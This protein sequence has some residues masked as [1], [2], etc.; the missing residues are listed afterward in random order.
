MKQCIVISASSA[1]V[2]QIQDALQLCPEPCEIIEAV[3]LDDAKDALQAT[4]TLVIVDEAFEKHS[5]AAFLQKA[6]QRC[7]GSWFISV[8]DMPYPEIA[9]LSMPLQDYALSFFTQHVRNESAES[10]TPQEQLAKV[11]PILLQHFWTGLLN[12]WIVPDET[13]IMMAAKGMYLDGLQSIHV[14]PIL[15][16]T[17]HKSRTEADKEMAAEHHLYFTNLIEREI[18]IKRHYGCALDRFSQKWAILLYIEKF[19]C[20]KE[21]LH[22]RFT[23]A[24]AAAAQAGWKLSFFTGR[25]VQPAHLLEVWN[26]LESLSERDVGYASQIVPLQEHMPQA[27]VPTPDMAGWRSLMESSHFEEVLSLASGYIMKLAQ[28][29]QL[30]TGWLYRFR[31]EFLLETYHAIQ[32]HGIPVEKILTSHLMGEEFTRCSSSIPQ[33]LAWVQG[34]LA[35][36]TGFL[37]TEQ[38]DTVVKRAQKYILQNLDQPLTR[39]EIAAHV[40][41][42][43]GYL[44][45]LFKKELHVSLSEYIFS[46][47][48][49]LAARMLT[50]TKLYITTIALNVG[51]SNFPYFSTQFKKYSGYSP[52]EY[53]RHWAE[54]QSSEE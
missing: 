53:R 13:M 48:M 36:F 41:V 22:R 51:Y 42:S 31:D 43:T 4:P 44:G 38:A 27:L 28:L 49:K 19:P 9:H 35:N 40:Y 10:I 45:R 29:D 47:R 33:L 37:D 14:F 39:D 46:E 1:F 52:V 12:E 24:I 2:T 34:I 25:S 26:E 6:S 5:L 23:R 18:L 50:E 20:S 54:S 11:Y 16:K 30:D 3:T 7:P 15:M 21:D 8:G 32:F 17:V